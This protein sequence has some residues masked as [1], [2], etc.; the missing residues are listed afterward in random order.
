MPQG[1]VEALL[2][3]EFKG[4]T[5]HDHLVKVLSTLVT[6]SSSD[7]YANFE[8]VSRFIKAEQGAVQKEVGECPGLEEN[9]AKT[10]KSR[11][12]P[13]TGEGEETAET[14]LCGVPDVASEMDK[15]KWASVGFSEA[16]TFAIACSLRQLASK[17]GLEKVRLW[18][19]ILGTK[20]DYIIAEANPY[21]GEIPE[22]EDL[23]K[24]NEPGLNFYSYWVTTNPYA[25][26]KDWEQLPLCR[27]EN[28]VS[29]RKVKKLFT[30]DLSAQV[31]THPHFHG[32]ER[33]LL[34][35]QIAR[36]SAGAILAPNGFY[37]KGEG[38]DG[39]VE[40]A[41]ILP[42]G[43]APEGD[44]GGFTF[45]LA[46]DLATLDQWVHARE[47]IFKTGKTKPEE[48]PEEGEEPEEKKKFRQWQQQQA[49]DP[50]V[51]PIRQVSSDAL[52]VGPAWSI[53][54]SYDAAE[55]CKT[56]PGEGG[57]GEGGKDIT[58]VSSQQVVSVKSLRWPGA[59][60]VYQSAQFVNLYC[61]YGWPV[62]T[63][64]PCAPEPVF[65]DEADPECAADVNEPPPPPAEEP[66]GEG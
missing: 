27:K 11:K 60:C 50:A 24:P 35:T 20:K 31:I 59:V 29:A 1:S 38:E 6:R 22:D 32:E 43:V 47:H 17:E 2:Q 40:V 16:E 28:V 9:L 55:C 7:A 45:P 42:P 53:T 34:R 13:A 8:V 62:G 15:L 51:A 52:P 37:V 39:T 19:K 23:D 25:E 10:F 61:G 44:E 4:Q 14:R 54:T 3:K 66:A 41:K 64:F 65:A 33:D 46:K 56:I 48:K 57:E 49:A 18:G 21:S 36:I 12:L 63:F 5:I 30:G 26:E 58:V